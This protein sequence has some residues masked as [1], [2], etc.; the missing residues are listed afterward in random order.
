MELVVAIRSHRVCDLCESATDAAP[1]RIGWGTSIYEADLCDEHLT[2]LTNALE[3]VLTNA[4]RIGAMPSST[5][6]PVRR[7]RRAR[8]D[9]AAVRAW[10]QKNGIEVSDKGRVSNALIEQYEEATRSS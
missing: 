2:L 1:I 7:K 6:A 5:P 8:V 9:T 3:N 4:R 10:A